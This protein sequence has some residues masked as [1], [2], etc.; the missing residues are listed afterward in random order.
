MCLT[1]EW[2]MSPQAIELAGWVEYRGAR[3]SAAEVSSLLRTD[4]DAVASFGGEFFL[5][6]EDCT[7]RDR[8]GVIPGEGPVGM[9]VCSGREVALVSPE[10]PSMPLA[11]AIARAVALRTGDGVVVALSGGVDSSLIA[12]LADRPC[13]AVGVEGCHDLVR[14]RSAADALG[15]ELAESVITPAEVEAALPEVVGAIPRVTPVDVSIA[16]TLYFVARAAAQAGFTRVMAGQGADELFGG[17]ARYR[18]SADLEDDLARDLAAIPAQTARDGAIGSLHGIFF[19]LPYL[20]ARVVRAATLIPAAEKVAGGV[21][22]RPLRTVAGALTG[23]DI[24]WLDKKAMQYGSGVWRV[25]QDC[26]R[27]NGYKKSVQGYLNQ[28]KGA[29]DGN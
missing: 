17:Y 5:A 28:I 26:A 21:G 11:D 2:L 7:A 12:A 24:A 16:A 9:V 22:K 18:E 15:L 19:T 20:D 4:P 13:L 1:G 27:H 8:F 10:V 23:P 6:W 25:I 3:L 29:S 14:A